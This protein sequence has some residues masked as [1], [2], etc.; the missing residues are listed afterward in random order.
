MKPLELSLRRTVEKKTLTVGMTGS[1]LG[2]STFNHKLAQRYLYPK[3]TATVNM[4]N[5]QQST[6]AKKFVLLFIKIY[7]GYISAG[8]TTL[9]PSFASSPEWFPTWCSLVNFEPCACFANT[10]LS[11]L[12]F[13]SS[14]LRDLLT[15]HAPASAWQRRYLRVA[16]LFLFLRWSCKLFLLHAGSSEG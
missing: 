13:C 1:S 15:T 12:P 10:L 9:F 4:P 3:K 14:Q 2:A 8:T 6:S 5:W 16:T 11:R 7:H